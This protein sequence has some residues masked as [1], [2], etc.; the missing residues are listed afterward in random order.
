MNSKTITIS[1]VTREIPIDR[2]MGNSSMRFLNLVVNLIRWDSS[3]ML[4]SLSTLSEVTSLFSSRLLFNSAQFQLRG[5]PKHIAVN[6]ELQSAF[7][8][9][10]SSFCL[11]NPGW[12]NNENARPIHIKAMNTA[13]AVVNNLG[14]DDLLGWR[15]FPEEL[16]SILFEYNKGDIN[17]AMSVGEDGFSTMVYGESFYESCNYRVLDVSPMVSFVKRV[18]RM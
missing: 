17:A 2:D 12:N 5:F 9:R 7:I 6:S 11:L 18:K 13:E 15:V 14:D 16:G 1:P 3:S 10:I 8:K 4:S